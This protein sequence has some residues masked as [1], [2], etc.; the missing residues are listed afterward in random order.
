VIQSRRRV[1]VLGTQIGVSGVR[2]AAE[3]MEFLDVIGEGGGAARWRLAG[4]WTFETVTGLDDRLRDLASTESTRE[5]VIDT[6]GVEALDSAGAW[7]LRRTIDTLGRRGAKVRI[8]GLSDRFSILLDQAGE[9]EAEELEEPGRANPLTTILERSGR[10][11]VEAGE[12]GR[13][14][15]GFF[16]LTLVTLGGLFTGRSRLRV[17]TLVN[18]MEAVGLNAPPSAIGPPQGD[19]GDGRGQLQRIGQ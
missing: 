2:V 10:A 15:L 4:P 1:T 9:G 3:G 14:L 12:V 8:D 11:V 16:G 6:A 7:V 17:I 18:Q 19:G 13:E 5:L